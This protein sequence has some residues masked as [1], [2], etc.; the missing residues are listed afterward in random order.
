MQ[1]LGGAA[2]ASAT[3]YDF[4]K[5]S[6]K[7]NEVLIAAHAQI[8]LKFLGVNPQFGWFVLGCMGSGAI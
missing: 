4:A 1:W 6:C 7:V 3:A 8:I 5:V 2:D